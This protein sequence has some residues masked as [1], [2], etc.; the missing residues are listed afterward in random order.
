MKG[1]HIKLFVIYLIL[2]IE[3]FYSQQFTVK[4]K[5]IVEEENPVDLAQLTFVRVNDTSKK[6]V[7]VTD[8]TGCYEIGLVTNVKTNQ[9]ELPKTLELSQN[10]PNPFTSSTAITYKI[11]TPV[12]GEV[13]IYNMLGQEIKTFQTKFYPKGLYSITWNGTNNSGEKISPGMYIYKFETEKEIVARKMIYGAGPTTYNTPN[14]FTSTKSLFSP[15]FT[16]FQTQ[17]T[18]DNTYHVIVESIDSTKPLIV[19]ESFAD[20]VVNG[21]TTLNFD[22]EKAR[23]ILGESIEGI[24]MGDDSLDVVNKLGMPDWID[25][26]DFDGYIFVYK[27]NREQVSLLVSIFKNHPLNPSGTIVLFIEVTESY[28]G[29][30]KEGAG[31]NLL[32]SEIRNL[33]GDPTASFEDSNGTDDY[34]YFPNPQPDTYSVSFD[35][36]YNQQDSLYRVTL[37]DDL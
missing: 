7:T 18:A 13:K 36:Y 10:Y 6:F 15:K 26:G 1:I 20:I 24:K 12:Y 37:Q 4:G 17:K 3:T 8:S 22:V 34:Y 14:V 9:V 19:M 28:T 33:I 23:I 21:D 35:F 31:M 11:N 16:Q 29:K 27:L 30:T 32:K 25:Y 2:F 5:I